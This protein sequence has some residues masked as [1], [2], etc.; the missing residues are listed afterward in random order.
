M[1]RCEWCGEAVEE[2]DAIVVSDGNVYH[3]QCCTYPTQGVST[4]MGSADDLMQIRLE[5]AMG[6]IADLGRNLRSR[7]K[8]L[9]DL[10]N[11][12][13]DVKSM[14]RFYKGCQVSCVL[15]ETDLCPTKTADKALR[16]W[17]E[18]KP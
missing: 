18:G 8:E 14:H 16:E 15:C 12:L 10:T 13:R 1:I 4:V 7:E 3:D 11:A 9:F 5:E 2:G 6:R 17:K